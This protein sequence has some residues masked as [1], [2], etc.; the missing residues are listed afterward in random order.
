MQTGI[1]LALISAALFGASTPLA[2]LMLG[3]V[4]PWMLAGLLYLGAGL[5]LAVFYL[6]RRAAPR[7]MRMWR[8]S[9]DVRTSPG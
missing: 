8:P 7:S 9:F 2:K 1:L 4:D 3:N 6:S 5:G